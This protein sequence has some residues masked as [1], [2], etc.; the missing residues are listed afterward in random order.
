MSVPFWV[1]FVGLPAAAILFAITLLAGLLWLVLTT[2]GARPR[3]FFAPFFKSFLVLVPLA[4][5]VLGPLLPAYL[6]TR[7]HHTRGDESFYRGPTI[8]A[9]GDWILATRE[10]G[11]NSAQPGEESPAN[12][13]AV[14][15]RARDGVELRAYL[16]RPREEA[17]PRAVAVLVHG[18]FRGGLEI[19]P[20]G[21]MFRDLGAAVLLLELRNHGRSDTA[22]ST[23]GATERLDVL[24]AAE[25]ARTEP[26][27]AESPLVVF[28]VSLGSAAVALA[29]PQIAPP[30]SA[31]VLDSPMASLENAADRLLSE[32]IGVPAP[33]RV[34]L[35]SALEVVGGF[36]FESV[37]P[38]AA[39]ARLD[40]SVRLLVIGGEEDELMP[41][42]DVRAM[43]DASPA[44]EKS[45][46]IVPGAGHGKSWKV[47][48]D[49]YRAR[50]AAL[51]EAIA[52]RS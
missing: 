9:S 44:R 18:L 48:P 42:G 40:P 46:W 17:K 19:E 12:P 34:G 49:E 28:G 24:A 13:H 32:R 20:V 38:A 31:V 10:R 14:T 7:S 47:A 4:L 26:G 25:F 8:D 51:I 50:L 11:R 27:L 3:R 5:F 2:C 36:R 30:P 29:T 37:V 16:V 15:L 41:P 22:V 39:I 23:F 43:F 35:K 21:A 1:G 6:V 52:P 33:F 45:M